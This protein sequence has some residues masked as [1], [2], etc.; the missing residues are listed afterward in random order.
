MKSSHQW[1][2]SF[3]GK[4]CAIIAIP[5]LQNETH[6]FTN[7]GV[8]S[9]FD[10]VSTEADMRDSNGR[11]WTTIIIE[12]SSEFATHIHANVDSLRTAMFS[13]MAHNVD[14]PLNPRRVQYLDIHP[15]NFNTCQGV[16]KETSSSWSI[17]TGSERCMGWTAR[18]HTRQLPS[19]GGRD[20]PEMDGFPS[21][22]Q[23]SNP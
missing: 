7:A 8:P 2:A 15:S 23:S 18:Y 19:T 17:N 3:P 14:T 6:N 20:R 21:T 12:S 9:A 11:H 10:Y 13:N 16:N 4:R 22:L 5:T 1:L